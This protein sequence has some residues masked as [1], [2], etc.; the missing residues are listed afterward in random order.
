MPID[1]G[2]GD[3]VSRKFDSA[4]KSHRAYYL[5]SQTTIDQLDHR[6]AWFNPT[7]GNSNTPNI[8]LMN[9]T[10]SRERRRSHQEHT[11]NT[12]NTGLKP[13]N[14][15][16]AFPNGTTTEARADSTSQHPFQGG[17]ISVERQFGTFR[18]KCINPT[19]HYATHPFAEDT[20]KL[21]RF[22]TSRAELMTEPN[23]TC[24]GGTELASGTK[25]VRFSWRPWGQ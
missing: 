18:I 2:G 9:T 17:F 8:Y 7:A 1:R 14:H 21:T 13:K 3:D 4:S 12:V 15:C 6:C 19:N 22:G 23:G 24:A 20:V 10:Y 16:A 5:T 25:P 11:I